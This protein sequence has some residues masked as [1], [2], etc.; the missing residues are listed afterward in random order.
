M[1]EIKHKGIFKTLYERKRKKSPGKGSGK[2]ALIAVYDKLIMVLWAIL[3]K[4]SVYQK[5]YD[6]KS[7]L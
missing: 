6:K 5:D 7:N 3:K 2:K 1:Q 4:E